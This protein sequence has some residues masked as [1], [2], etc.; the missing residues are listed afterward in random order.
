MRDKPY[1]PSAQAAGRAYDELAL[2]IIYQYSIYRCTEVEKQLVLPIMYQYSETC[3]Y[4]H[5]EGD[6]VVS[7][8]TL[9]FL[10]MLQ[11]ICVATH[12][13]RH[14]TSAFWRIH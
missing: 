8:K 11:T 13:T 6:L 14:T 5:T 2:P 4:A 12:R 10:E 9:L 7:K 1:K 3:I